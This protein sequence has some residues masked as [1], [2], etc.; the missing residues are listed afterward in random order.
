LKA[1]LIP[2]VA[3]GAEQFKLNPDEAHL[4]QAVN[5]WKKVATALKNED[6]R[7]SF[8]LMI[9]PWKN[10]KKYSN[11]LYDFYDRVIS[12]IRSTWGNNKYRILFLAP[13]HLGN[14]EYLNDL[15]QVFDKHKS[16]KYLMAQFHFLAAG[17]FR[18]TNK[19]W[20]RLTWNGSGTTQEKQKIVSRLKIA[21]D[22]Q[23]RTG[24]RIWFWAWMPGNYNHTYDGWDNNYSIQEQVA[25]A[26][27]M[28]QTLCKM[29]IPNAVNAD[30]QFY[31]MK[32]WKW[33][34]K[35]LPVIEVIT[36]SCK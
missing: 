21:L 24:R 31:D 12:A 30:S 18:T 23:K 1:W 35:L 34:T 11:M 5:I 33:K 4:Q 13:N 9:E 17:P 26:K 8:D 7:V 19:T 6:Y 2:V 3:F 16:D 20:K 14:P 36:S 15:T 27:F 25:F 32:T 29:W 22:W 28:E 10:L